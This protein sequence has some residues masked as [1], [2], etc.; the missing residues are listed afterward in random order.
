MAT[1]RTERLVP[2]LEVIMLSPKGVETWHDW[3]FKRLTAL[4]FPIDVCAVIGF[5]AGL[6]L[7]LVGGGIL[8]FVLL[9]QEQIG[10]RVFVGLLVLLLLAGPL[11]GGILGA[12]GG[13]LVF[14][15]R[16]L[17]GIPNTSDLTNPGESS[18]ES[19]LP[20]TDRNQRANQP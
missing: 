6:C 4:P 20:S 16:R 13:C 5:L 1:A 9:I 7:G 12:L 10:G 8:G 3:L 18:L 17:L 14:A 15:V 19:P 11:L 2:L